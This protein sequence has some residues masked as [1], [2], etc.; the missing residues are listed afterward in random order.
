MT[1]RSKPVIPDP[2]D[3]SMRLILLATNERLKIPS[4]LL[5]DLLELEGLSDAQKALIQQEK[6]TISKY[7]LTLGYDEM[8]TSLYSV[9]IFLILQLKLSNN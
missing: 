9:L 8:T 3:E 1:D 5:A 7:V 2:D 4:F 6:P